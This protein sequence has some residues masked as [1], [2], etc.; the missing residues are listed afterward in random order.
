MNDDKD[1]FRGTGEQQRANLRNAILAGDQRDDG[2]L[3]D[4]MFIGVAAYR[5]MQ[6]IATTEGV[7]KVV[8]QMIADCEI[9]IRAQTM[10][11]L[12]QNDPASA[13]ARTAH[14]EARVAAR[15]VGLLNDY[16]ARGAQAQD[17][18]NNTPSPNEQLS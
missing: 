2:L 10:V 7:A 3:Y 1:W 5:I 18:I 14:F 9:A 12:A 6:G 15:M 13:E 4:Q 11:I 17:T 8:A 16:V